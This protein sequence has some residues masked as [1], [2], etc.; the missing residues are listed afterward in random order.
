MSMKTGSFFFNFLAMTFQSVR[1]STIYVDLTGFLS[2]SA[3]TGDNL[4]PDL[5]LVLPYKCFYSLEL[6]VGCE[7]N[8]RKSYHRKRTKHHDLVR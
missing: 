6:T 8:I 4:R 1:D 5:L 7:S 3:I 2:P